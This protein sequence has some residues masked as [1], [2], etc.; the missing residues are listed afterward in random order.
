MV[1]RFASD[2]QPRKARRVFRPF[3][4][5]SL[6]IFLAVLSLV[7]AACG[8][9]PP[10]EGREGSGETT[11]GTTGGTT[12]ETTAQAPFRPEEGSLIIYSGR[13]EALV[14]DVIEQFEKQ[15]GVDVQ[16]RYGDTA[17]LGATILE[18]GQ[19]SPADVFFAQDPGALGAVADA[20][21]L[22][23]LPQGILERVRS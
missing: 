19:N 5:F 21:A 17:E 8:Q 20:G 2:V 23:K 12:A 18:E 13:E 9:Q 11:G 3:R 14:G 16:V 10:S 6:C 15:S 22:Q 1:Y 4:A 7:V